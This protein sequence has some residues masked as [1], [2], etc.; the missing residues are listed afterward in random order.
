[1]RRKLGS[2]SVLKNKLRLVSKVLT[3]EFQIK[4]FTIL[5]RKLFNQEL[6]Q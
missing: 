2:L 6:I 4:K 3:R 1:M 5:L